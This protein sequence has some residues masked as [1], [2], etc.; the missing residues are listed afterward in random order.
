[1]FSIEL[2]NSVLSRLVGCAGALLFFSVTFPTPIYPFFRIG[3]ELNLCRLEST[4]SFR[5]SSNFVKLSSKLGARSLLSDLQRLKYCSTLLTSTLCRLLAALSFDNELP[6]TFPWSTVISFIYLK[7]F[8][9]SWISVK[10]V[11]GQRI[12]R[13][14]SQAQ[15]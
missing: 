6:A 5:S 12:F 2:G 8:S 15:K 3:G 11:S 9:C 1:M 4:F 14:R 7:R 10:S 13:S